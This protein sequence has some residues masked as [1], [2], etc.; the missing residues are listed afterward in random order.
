MAGVDEALT[1]LNYRNPNALKYK[2]VHA[3]RGLYASDQ[4]L[5]SLKKANDRKNM[6][7]V[8]TIIRAL[9]SKLTQLNDEI[10][11]RVKEQE[12][13]EGKI[14]EDNKMID[15]LTQDI[16]EFQDIKNFKILHI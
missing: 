13:L 15:R 4:A 8:L 9:N 10:D 3:I 5:N 6:I 1:H 11:S 2:F 14:E 7:K 12:Q 16:E